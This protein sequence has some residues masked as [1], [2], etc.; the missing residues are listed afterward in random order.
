MLSTF[1]YSGNLIR[2]NNINQVELM[3]FIPMDKVLYH[4]N[5]SLFLIM[6]SLWNVTIGRTI[7]EAYT[8]STPV[9]DIYGR[10]LTNQS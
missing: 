4:L 10:I 6:L 1:L 8:C 2:L 9:M 7:I 3:G 5:I